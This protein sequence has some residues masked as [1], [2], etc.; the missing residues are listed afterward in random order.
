LDVELSTRHSLD[1]ELSTRHSLDV[2]QGVIGVSPHGHQCHA[3]LW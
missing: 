1:V 2:E 3:T